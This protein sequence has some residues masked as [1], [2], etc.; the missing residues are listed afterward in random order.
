MPDYEVKLVIKYLQCE[1]DKK[2][3]MPEKIPDTG[4]YANNFNIFRIFDL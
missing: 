1:E 2:Y 4:R 3:Q